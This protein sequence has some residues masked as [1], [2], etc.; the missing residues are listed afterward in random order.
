MSLKLKKMY[1]LKIAITDKKKKQRIRRSKYD[2]ELGFIASEY[3]FRFHA[4]E[5]IVVD[6]LQ[7][8]GFNVRR[9]KIKERDHKGITVKWCL[10]E[11]KD[12]RRRGQ[13]GGC[14]CCTDNLDS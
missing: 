6:E 9:I 2:E 5:R 3:K 12:K 10:K 14:C 7:N 8:A 11:A 13:S 4:I 1:H